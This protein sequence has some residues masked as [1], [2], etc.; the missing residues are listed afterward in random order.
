MAE[1]QI[2]LARADRSHHV[3][4]RAP[5]CVRKVF[6][7]RAPPLAGRPALLAWDHFG[8]RRIEEGHGLAAIGE[9]FKSSIRSRCH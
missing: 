1:H 2:H 4:A 7:S 8:V 9:S 6:V 3:P 5:H